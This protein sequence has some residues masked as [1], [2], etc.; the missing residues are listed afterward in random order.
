MDLKVTSFTILATSAENIEKAFKR[1]F[2]ATNN[3]TQK[4]FII[5]TCFYSQKLLIHSNYLTFS[6]LIFKQKV[7]RLLKSQVKNHSCRESSQSGQVSLGPPNK[8]KAQ[9]PKNDVP[10]NFLKFYSTSNWK[11]V[12]TLMKVSIKI[13]LIKRLRENFFFD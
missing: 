9:L 8:P 2:Y 7:V 12:Q 10:K 11:Q 3:S 13:Q 6:L 1:R 5:V 4:T